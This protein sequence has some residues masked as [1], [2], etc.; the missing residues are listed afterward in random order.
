MGKG[1]ACS[2]DAA[3]PLLSERAR[4]G[5]PGSLVSLESSEGRNLTLE[6]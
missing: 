2:G 1:G 3:R 6:V 5:Y 4:G